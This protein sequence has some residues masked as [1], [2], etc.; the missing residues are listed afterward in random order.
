MLNHISKVKLSVFIGAIALFLG[1]NSIVAQTSPHDEYEEWQKAQRE[2]AREHREYLNNPKRSNYLDWRSAQRD[3]N[4]EHEE[5]LL[6]MEVSRRYYKGGGRWYVAESDIN[7]EYEDWKAA[8]RELVREHQEY[9]NNPTRSNYQGWMDAKEDVRREYSEYRA[10][11]GK[12]TSTATGKR[13][14]KV[15]YV[16]E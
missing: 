3:A 5:Y 10:A 16:Y 4:R 15:V 12:A 8:Q 14:R 13:V 7:D 1:V 9:L 2:A 6:A 11:G